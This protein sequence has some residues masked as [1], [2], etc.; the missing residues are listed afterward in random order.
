M[1]F[2]IFTSLILSFNT[3]INLKYTAIRKLSIPDTGSNHLRFLF[4][5]IFFGNLS[6]I[7][8][9]NFIDVNTFQ[10]SFFY[11]ILTSLQNLYFY[12]IVKLSSFYNNLYKNYYKKIT[13]FIFYYK[14]RNNK[15][16]KFPFIC[17]HMLICKFMCIFNKFKIIYLFKYKFT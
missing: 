3:S 5:H 9:T 1:F 8:F 6:N 17:V 11:I 15:I 13:I 2:L 10:F 16:F 12:F 7:S 14:L 4:F